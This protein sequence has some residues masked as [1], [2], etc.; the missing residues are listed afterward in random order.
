M[1]NLSPSYQLKGVVLY[2]VI[3]K[4][5][6]TRDSVFNS[7]QLILQKPIYWV[8]H[9]LWLVSNLQELLKSSMIGLH[10]GSRFQKLI[11]KKTCRQ[12]FINNL[13]KVLCGFGVR[14]KD[15]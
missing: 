4:R 13:E 3:V 15:R 11:K 12:K 8:L 9:F 2:S 10:V 6:R 1:I 7:H 5:F 14:A